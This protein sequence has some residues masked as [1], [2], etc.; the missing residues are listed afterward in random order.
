MTQSRPSPI[1]SAIVTV[2][3]KADFLPETIDSLRRQ[4][5]DEHQIEYIFVD[6]AS[7]DQ[8]MAIIR[9]AMRGA[10]YVQIIANENNCGP[11]IRLNQGAG[12]A[13]A[14]YLYF[15]DGD[16]LACDG[17]MIGMLERLEKEDADLIYGKTLASNRAQKEANSTAKSDS[18]APYMI[19]ETPLSYIVRGGF[20]RMALMCKR[21]LFLKADGADETIFV[22]DESLPLRLG[23]H[24][25]RFLDWQASVIA[26]PGCEGQ[27][28]AAAHHVSSNKTQ[29]H[30]DA[31]FANAKALKAFGE[32]YPEVAS[33]LYTRAVSAYW[34]YAKRQPGSMWLHPGFWRYLQAKLMKP[35]PID[36]VLEWM[37]AELKALPNVRRPDCSNT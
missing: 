21:A 5:P 32:R 8:S 2:F 12:K 37:A 15:L 6:D 24:A 13:T 29:L 35:E 25:S 14:P 17:A 4:M 30:H 10:P 11:S 3:N 26:R 34:K 19:S 31:F 18:K 16:D 33:P 9:E 22:Q 7:T 36:D 28:G 20:V 1:V 27:S 23:A